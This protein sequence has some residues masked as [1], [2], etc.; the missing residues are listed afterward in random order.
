MVQRLHCRIV[1][2]ALSLEGIAGLQEDLSIFLDRETQDARKITKKRSER[3]ISDTACSNTQGAR[4]GSSEYSSTLGN[5]IHDALVPHAG[6]NHGPRERLINDSNDDP[7]GAINPKDHGLLTDADTALNPTNTVDTDETICYAPSVI[8][9]TVRPHVHEIVAEQVYREI[10]NHDVY[11]RV[12]P[13]YDI[14]FLPAR[15]FV[16]GP[17]GNLVEVAEEELPFAQCAGQNQQW[18]IGKKQP[19]VTS[20]TSK[21][22]PEASSQHSAAQKPVDSTS[23]VHLMSKTLDSQGLRGMDHDSWQSSATRA[24]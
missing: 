2:E 8:H 17:N 21:E 18:F 1:E 16:P 15:H 22:N 7:V 3:D 14:E 5:R 4:G 12:Q 6:D 20:S 19:P 9:E 23:P 10:H 24:M 13:V 11:H